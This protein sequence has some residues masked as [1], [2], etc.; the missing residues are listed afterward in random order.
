MDSVEYSAK[1]VADLR[2]ARNMALTLTA[3]SGHP[4]P[5]RD[6]VL[7]L[8]TF[9]RQSTGVEDPGW[10]ALDLSKPLDRLS[11][12]TEDKRILI[13]VRG[14]RLSQVIASFY[15]DLDS[16]EVRLAGDRYEVWWAHEDDA[17]VGG[18]A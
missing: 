13:V 11:D 8:E 9:V 15:A 1:R 4:L 18:A 7:H 10:R 5:I 16:P 3:A 17:D 12:G 6:G 2:T 14:W